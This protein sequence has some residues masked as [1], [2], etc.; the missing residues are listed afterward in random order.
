MPLMANQ[1]PDDIAELKRLLIAK[2]AA[3]VAKDAELV[4]AR[5]GLV[6]TQLTVEKLK[7]QLAK[8]RR[9]KF[10]P[11]SERIERAIAQLELALEEAQAAKAEAI[12]SVAQAPDPETPALTADALAA[13]APVAE[14]KKRRTCRPSC[15][16]GTSCM[17]RL[18]SA[19]PAA[20][21]ICARS[22]RA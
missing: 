5:N 3:L 17:H 1:L 4:A 11:S 2:D 20:A 22:A 18:T 9:E 6:I 19:K 13:G 8:L 15:R 14:K 16:A 12:A 7:A 21:M 10:G